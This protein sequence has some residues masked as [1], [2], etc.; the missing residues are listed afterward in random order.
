[1]SVN[2][3]TEWDRPVDGIE[4]TFY[5]K[6]YRKDTGQVLGKISKTADSSWRAISIAPDMNIGLYISCEAAMKAVERYFNS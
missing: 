4:R 1:M 5:G 3:N 6:F 2:S